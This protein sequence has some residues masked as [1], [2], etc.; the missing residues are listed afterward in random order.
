MGED[1]KIVPPENNNTEYKCI[2][3]PNIRLLVRKM[4]EL[5]IPKEN[6]VSLLFNE[7]YILVYS[8]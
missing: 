2:A 3:E 8:E 5:G 1:I 4:N 6:I 7:Q